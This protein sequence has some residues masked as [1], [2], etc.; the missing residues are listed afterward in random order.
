VT[1][2]FVGSRTAGFYALWRFPGS[3]EDL[4]R[5][6]PE[7]TAMHRVLQ[8]YREPL[9]ADSGCG[10]LELLVDQSIGALEAEERDADAS[11]RADKDGVLVKPRSGEPFTLAWPAKE[12]SPPKKERAVSAPVVAV[13]LALLFA[14]LWLCEDCARYLGQI[15]RALR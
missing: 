12:A 4:R 7:L 8:H 2:I 14:L 9:P 6:W 15:L 13:V 5:S 3:L 1:E 11:M 10:S